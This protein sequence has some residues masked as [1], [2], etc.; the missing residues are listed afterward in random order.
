M[1]CVM[2]SIN[3]PEDAKPSASAETVAPKGASAAEDAS[4]MSVSS[5]QRI[6]SQM[7]SDIEA[8]LARGGKIEHL[9]ITMSAEK[10][11]H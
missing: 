3:R 10:L 5:R 2:G 4:H 11:N 9:D 8:F 6:R 1:A 7:E